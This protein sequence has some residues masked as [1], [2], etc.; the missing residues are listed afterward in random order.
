MLKQRGRVRRKIRR[1]TAN[2]Q[3][4]RELERPRWSNLEKTP[5]NS[6]Q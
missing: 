6:A 4:R 3:A 1:L 2:K 5:L